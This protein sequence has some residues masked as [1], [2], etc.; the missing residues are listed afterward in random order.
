M[1]I[2]S[3]VFFKYFWMESLGKCVQQPVDSNLLHMLIFILFLFVVV[4]VV[5]VLLNLLYYYEIVFIIF[6]TNS[7][8]FFLS[9]L[10]FFIIYLLIFLSFLFFFLFFL[11]KCSSAKI[12]C[13]VTYLVWRFFLVRKLPSGACVGVSVVVVY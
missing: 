4:L 3:L 10:W 13:L 2:F 6:T 12:I 1:L 9:S 8:F 5:V 7:I 11:I